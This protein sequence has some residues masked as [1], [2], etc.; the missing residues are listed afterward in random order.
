M[1]IE[2]QNNLP[3]IDRKAAIIAALP[4]FIFG[5]LIT[6]I[7]IFLKII[8]GP[9]QIKSLKVDYLWHNLAIV[10]SLIAL[11]V[12][13][14]VAIC[15]IRNRLVIWSYTWLGSILVGLIVSLNLVIDDRAFAF[16]KIIDTS[17]VLLILFFCLIIFFKIVLNSW[18]HTGLL[19]I[20]L[21]GTLGLSLT[22]FSVAGS[23]P[24][25][26]SIGLS[27]SVIGLIEALIVYKFLLIKSKKVR[28]FLITGVGILNIG[29]AWIVELILRSSTP[30]RD[31][32]Q[33]IMLAALLTILLVGGTLSGSIAQLIRQKFLTGN[34]KTM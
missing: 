34:N 18:H 21:C 13:L 30:A 6:C 31:I 4:L 11:S 2:I 27:S 26:A 14:Y 12:L 22:F 8:G 5:L 15:A 10:I 3:N 25:H 32:T 17:L 16:S 1:N 29:I 24:F 20:G 9:S 28:V 19:S 7:T 23:G 33:F